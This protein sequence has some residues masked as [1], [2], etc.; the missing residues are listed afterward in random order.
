NRRVID[1]TVP[2]NKFWEKTFQS[3]EEKVFLSQYLW[4][5]FFRGLP[6]RLWY[7][8]FF[9]FFIFVCLIYVDRYRRGLSLGCD[10]CGRAVCKKCK[11]FVSEYNLCKECA[12]IFKGNKNISISVKNKEC[13]VILIER[14][15]KRHLVIGKI[16][17]FLL[18]GAGHLLLDKPV[19]GS[20]ML[21]GF[22]FLMLKIV[23]T[24]GFIANPWQIVI[25]SSYGGLF[26]LSSLLLVLYGYSIAD[27]SKVSVKVSQFISLIRATRKELQIQH[28][29]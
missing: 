27:F 29:G 17:S 21:F 23:F 7:A 4:N 6:Y 25:A 10:Y 20:L 3:S 11:T 26:L 16:L 19:K 28:K 8:V 5:S 9:V 15:H 1:E 18:P 13:Q 12:G 24:D 22:F 14:F 2:V